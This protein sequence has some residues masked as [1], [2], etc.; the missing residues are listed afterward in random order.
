MRRNYA[1]LRAGRRHLHA[2]ICQYLRSPRAT[3]FSHKTMLRQEEALAE[4]DDSIDDWVSKLE[5]VENRRTRVRQKLLEHVAA[6]TMLPVPRSPGAPAES[7]QPALGP[8]SPIPGGISTPPESPS[9]RVFPEL[10]DVGTAPAGEQAPGLKRADVES[11]RVYVEGDIFALL[12]DVE[13]HITRMSTRRLP[14]SPPGSAA[15]GCERLGSADGST[16]DPG[17]PATDGGAGLGPRL[18]P[19]KT[20][21]LVLSSAVFKP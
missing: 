4:L 12:A 1:A 10:P 21:D 5:H 8:M 11:I 20:T 18:P 15:P 14:V 2:R 19:L 13:N 7:L 16:R 9:R 6:A 3:R 17:S